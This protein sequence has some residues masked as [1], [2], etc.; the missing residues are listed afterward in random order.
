MKQAAGVR[1]CGRC[2]QEVQGARVAGTLQRAT[3]SGRK[4][5]MTQRDEPPRFVKRR[6]QRSR[7]AVGWTP[8]CG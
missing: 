1:R 4:R 2:E 6:R 7:I 3:T 8:K 5:R